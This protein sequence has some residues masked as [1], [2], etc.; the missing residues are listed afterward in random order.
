MTSQIL[1]VLVFVLMFALI[2]T[3]KIERHLATLLCGLMTIVLVFGV[4]MHSMDAVIKTLNIHSIFT[5]EFWYQA[6]SAAEE[7]SGI[8]WATIIFM[9]V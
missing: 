8:N 7:S 1:A 6:G 3:E 9:P 4:S 5:T 2:I